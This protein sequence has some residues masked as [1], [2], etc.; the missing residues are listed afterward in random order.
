M[1]RVLGNIV[2]FEMSS[3][4]PA[5]HYTVKVYAVRD[6][7]KSAATTTEFTTGEHSFLKVDLFA[8]LLALLILT[9]SKIPYL[10][11]TVQIAVFFI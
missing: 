8:K 4:T 6:L 2:E 10:Q 3:L 7:A 11:S 1:E 5:I 9:K